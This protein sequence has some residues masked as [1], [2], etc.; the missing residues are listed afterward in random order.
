MD[1][2]KMKTVAMGGVSDGSEHAMIVG[3]TVY[4]VQAH[5]MSDALIRMQKKGFKTEQW[6]LSN[7]KAV[8]IPGLWEYDMATFQGAV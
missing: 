2:S 3:K 4:L 5:G 7:E 6:K 1:I 8:L